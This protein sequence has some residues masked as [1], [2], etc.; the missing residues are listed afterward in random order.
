M[1][2]LKKKKRKKIKPQ[3]FL[4]RID[5]EVD[6]E[7]DQAL[8]MAER[9]K[10][11]PAEKII[12]QLL[13]ENPDIYTVQYAMGVICAMKGQFAEAIAYFDKAIAI[14]PYCVEAWF[15]KGASHQKNKELDEMIRA[16]QKVVE[17]G[18]PKED[19]VSQARAIIKDIEVHLFESK[20]LTLDGYLKGWKKFQEAFAAMEKGQLEIALSGFQAVLAIDPKHT[21]SYGNMGICYARLGHKQKALTSLDKALELDSNYEPALLNR[22]VVSLLKEGEKLEDKSKYESVEYYKDYAVKKKSLLESLFG[23]FWT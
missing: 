5:Q 15:N 13:K 16:F 20:G 2:T 12:S 4:M 17:L 22:E 1:T 23:R 3:N 14:F 6:Q 8:E 19:F 21:Q 10:I 7:V 11:S 9:G 18:D